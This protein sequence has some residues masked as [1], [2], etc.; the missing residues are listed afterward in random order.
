MP[1]FSIATLMAVGVGKPPI[2]AMLS[3]PPSPSGA[4]AIL[5]VS[6]IAIMLALIAA[7]SLGG[8]I[9]IFGALIIGFGTVIEAVIA[10]AIL[11]LTKLFFIYYLA[12]DNFYEWVQDQG[13][14]ISQLFSELMQQIT[15][16]GHPLSFLI[17]LL[18][19][20]LD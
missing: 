20:L 14:N 11:I 7:L 10:S 18:S 16:P 12:D 1:F 6:T 13:G 2:S 8:A 4:L 5:A 15:G 3:I 19:Q 17:E 9:T